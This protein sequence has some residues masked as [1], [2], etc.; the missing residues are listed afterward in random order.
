MG[1]AEISSRRRAADRMLERT[2]A[3]RAKQEKTEQAVQRFF[4]LEDEGASEVAEL[5]TLREQLAAMDQIVSRIDGLE[6]RTG[7]RRLEQAQCVMDLLAIDKTQAEV[8]ELLEVSRGVL[9]KLIDEAPVASA[10]GRP[11]PKLDEAPADRPTGG[12]GVAEAS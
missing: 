6:K 2:A 10:P 11:E 9:R 4:E 12:D 1:S 7:Q 5:K 8:A 3:L